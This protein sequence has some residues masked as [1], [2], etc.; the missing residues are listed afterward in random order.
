MRFENL[1]HR[2]ISDV[3]PIG[4]M[5]DLLYVKYNVEDI[6]IQFFIR[7]VFWGTRH[8]LIVQFDSSYLRS[9]RRTA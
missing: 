7:A 8:N 2:R 6:Y 4:L 1:K 5:R 9:P 3:V